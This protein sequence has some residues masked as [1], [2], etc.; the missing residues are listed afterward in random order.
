MVSN[1]NYVEKPAN[2]TAHSVTDDGLF[3]SHRTTFQFNVSTKPNLF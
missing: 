3:E 2:I 1:M